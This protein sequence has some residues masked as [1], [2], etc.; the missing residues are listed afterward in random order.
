MKKSNESKFSVQIDD[1]MWQELERSLSISASEIRAWIIRI[2]NDKKYI[3]RFELI[4][5]LESDIK[6]T[7]RTTG[8]LFYRKLLLLWT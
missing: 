3:D 6:H 7:S 1:N 2:M 4:I 8:S 5:F